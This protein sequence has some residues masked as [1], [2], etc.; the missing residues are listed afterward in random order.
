MKCKK[1]DISR[2]QCFALEMRFEYAL[3][4]CHIYCIHLIIVQ[5]VMEDCLCEM[6][7]ILV[8]GKGVCPSKI[9]D[10]ITFDINNVTR[11]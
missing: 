9:R 4:Y 5:V 8:V 1:T 10:L 7:W 3:H 2:P 11:Y 6:R